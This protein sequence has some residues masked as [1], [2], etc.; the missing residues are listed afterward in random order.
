MSRTQIKT[1][2]IADNSITIAKLDST[3]SGALVPIGGIIMWS[4]SIA[5]IPTNWALCDGTNG[6]PD[7]RNKFI[8]AAGSDTGNYAWNATTG[9]VTGNYAPGNTGGE[10]AHQLIVAELASHTHTVTGTSAGNG[11]FFKAFFISIARIGRFSPPT[12]LND[13]INGL[14]EG[15]D[16]SDVTTVG[17]PTTATSSV[18]RG[19]LNNSGG[20]KYHE[21]RPPYY[22]LAFI[23]RVL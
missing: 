19:Q 11:G 16:F 22:A 20:N 17:D 12:V 4:G 3:S 15:G 5:A 6:T 21:N 13:A 14:T 2:G 1:P 18:G 23:M 7:L 8:V 9:A 10:A